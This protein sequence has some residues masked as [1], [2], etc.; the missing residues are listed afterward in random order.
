MFLIQPIL[1]SVIIIII[2]FCDL[3]II[4]IRRLTPECGELTSACFS[5]FVH[6]KNPYELNASSFVANDLEK[7]R[8]VTRSLTFSE[9]AVEVHFY[10]LA[11]YIKYTETSFLKYKYV[12]N[13]L[14]SLRH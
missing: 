14:F 5:G 1:Y 9:I 11:L 13:M 8:V 3:P 6:R 12:Q 7:S 4:L 2:I 10:L